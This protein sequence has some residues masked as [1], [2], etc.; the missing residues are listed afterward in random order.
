MPRAACILLLLA[1]TACNAPPA[2]VPETAG[3]FDTALPLG[4]DA[5]WRGD[6]TAC[7]T[8]DVPVEECLRTTMR[9]AEATPA[10]LAA[11][12]RVADRGDAGYIAAWRES[13]GVG[14]ATPEYPF[15]ANTN[16][17]TWLVDA[18]GRVIDVDDDPLADVDTGRQDLVAFR[19]AHPDA[20][21]V[22]PAQP[23][24]SEALAGGGVR[25]LFVTPMRTCRACADVGTLRMGYDFDEARRFSGRRVIGIE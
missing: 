11:N 13:D 5:V 4:P 21:P 25:L 18:A 12:A 16:Q 22:A 1:L 8:G 20:S 2:I 3:A 17:G 24:G 9:D 7:R 14:I 23:D 15:R 6:V 19:R 10:A